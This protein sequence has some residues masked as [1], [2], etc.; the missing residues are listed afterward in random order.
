MKPSHFEQPCCLSVCLSV[1]GI[2]AESNVALTD[3][4][5]IGRT[6][7]YGTMMMNHIPCSFYVCDPVL[8][9]RYVH[10]NISHCAL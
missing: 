1:F 6:R 4:L 2:S 10:V 7:M 3:Q 8:C 9:N 5:Q